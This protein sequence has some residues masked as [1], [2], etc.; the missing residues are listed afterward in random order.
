[1]NI[2]FVQFYQGVEG[3][4]HTKRS[5]NAKEFKI[6]KAVDG[7]YFENTE[8]PF[9]THIPWNNVVQIRYEKP[10]AAEPAK[11]KKV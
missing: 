3:L 5:I 6:T 11:V 7:I 1:M 8:Y 4:N 2:E 9:I 10:V